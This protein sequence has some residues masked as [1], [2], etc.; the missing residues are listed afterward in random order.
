MVDF[1]KEEAINSLEMLRK[2]KGVARIS[3]RNTNYLGN[4]ANDMRKR[5]VVPAEVRKGHEKLTLMKVYDCV[6]EELVDPGNE[7][8][9]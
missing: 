1:H 8:H 4:M 5:S 7:R 6:A 9:V 2:T 3:E